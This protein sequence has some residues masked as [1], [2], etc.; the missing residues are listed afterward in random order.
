MAVIEH[1]KKKT[2]GS[3]CNE[4]NILIHK[5]ILAACHKQSLSQKVGQMTS[6]MTNI[7]F[8]YYTKNHV[9]LVIWFVSIA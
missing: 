4:W 3:R 6:S 8:D 2:M 7:E 9:C 1:R 5:S